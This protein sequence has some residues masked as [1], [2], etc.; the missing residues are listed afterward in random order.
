M[1]LSAVITTV[2]TH[3]PVTENLN[4]PF[5]LGPVTKGF[6]PYVVHDAIGFGANRVYK[7]LDHVLAIFPYQLP[8][9]FKVYV[10]LRFIKRPD[11]AGT[12]TGVDMLVTFSVEMFA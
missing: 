4:D 1:F 9:L 3:G 12:G 7:L 6:E 5:A 8:V 11:E 10:A 2:K